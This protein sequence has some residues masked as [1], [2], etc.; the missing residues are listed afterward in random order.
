MAEVVTHV[1]TVLDPQEAPLAAEYAQALADR[2]PSNEEA[3]EL[4][5][6]LEGVVKLLDEVDGFDQ[7]LT[8][9]TLSAAQRRDMVARI[10]RDKMSE[11]M[12]GL[13]SVLARQM[14]LGLLRSISKE[15]R[16]KLDKR[17]GRINVKVVTAVE[18]DATQ[19]EAIRKMLRDETGLEPV[20][21]ITVDRELIGGIVLEVGDR[22]FDTSLSGRLRR[23]REDLLARSPHGASK[24]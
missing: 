19:I 18:P 13:F 20:L 10:A 3:V 9:A 4:A 8:A 7:L 23:M 6:E 14:R 15:F 2:A 11:T 1:K 12:Q 17:Q 22:V 24:P 16:S 5:C 21:H